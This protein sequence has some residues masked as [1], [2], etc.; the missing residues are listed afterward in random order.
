[1]SCAGGLAWRGATSATGTARTSRCFGSAVR[2]FL[3]PN[4]TAASSASASA[5]AS[6]STSSVNCA[7][8]PPASRFMEVGELERLRASATV[9]QL[10]QGFVV[11]PDPRRNKK[12]GSSAQTTPAPRLLGPRTWADDAAAAAARGWASLCELLRMRVFWRALWCSC[13]LLLISKQWG[14]LDQLL[15]AYLERNYGEGVPIYRIHSINTYGCSLD[16]IW[17]AASI[18]CGHSLHC[19]RM[20]M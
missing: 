20:H 1:M 15:P 7:S 16:P 4:A 3:R 6:A 19:L 5:S 14:D 11:A 18:T 12:A 13:C 9:Q 10:R 8:S 17:V 2:R